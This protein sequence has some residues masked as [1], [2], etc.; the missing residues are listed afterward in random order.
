MEGH[1]K[2][3]FTFNA[4]LRNRTGEKQLY[5]LR[6]NVPRGWNVIFKPNYKQATSVEIEANGTASFN[7]EVNP[8]DNLQAGTYT[9]PVMAVTSSTSA[10]LEL[11]VVI[12]GSYEMELTTPTG[13]LSTRVTAG[14]EKTIT[15]LVRNTGSAKL[16]N[17][18]LSSSTPMNWGVTFDP[19][20]IE[21][22]EAGQNETVLA[23][24]KVD[25]KAIAGDYATKLT[26]KTPEVTSTAN[27]RIAVKTPMLWGWI[28]IAI[29]LAALGSMIYLFRKYG[30]R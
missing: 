30:R 6:A 22:L 7:I 17:I 29:I 16:Q 19:E 27:F 9:I 24:I 4:E 25:K 2:S 15:L 14:D 28:G 26:A 5:S 23:T 11:E 13:L 12:T 8:P 18:D 10:K 3:D 21:G 1:A 20:K